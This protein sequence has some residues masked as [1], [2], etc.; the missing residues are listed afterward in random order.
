[1]AFNSR[2]GR[3]LI[4]IIGICVIS[5]VS[6]ATLKSSS[7][8]LEKGQSESVIKSAEKQNVNSSG[9]KEYSV[10]GFK[11]SS[12]PEHQSYILFLSGFF[13]IIGI[14]WVKKKES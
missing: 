13:G 3:I 1:M 11:I 12:I 14:G 7:Y 9:K 10:A 5:F 4:M 6:A 2:A 8:F